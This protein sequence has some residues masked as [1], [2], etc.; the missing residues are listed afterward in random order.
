MSRNSILHGASFYQAQNG[1]LGKA[2]GAGYH[3]LSNATHLIRFVAVR[4]GGTGSDGC[5]E[6]N[7]KPGSGRKPLWPDNQYRYNNRPQ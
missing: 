2:L 6:N 4:G 3:G 5:A 7:A 1:P